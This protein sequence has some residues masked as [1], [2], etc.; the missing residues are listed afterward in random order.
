MSVQLILRH[1]QADIYTYYLQVSQL[2]SSL[3]YIS[4]HS[5]NTT[6][7]GPQRGGTLLNSQNRR[8]RL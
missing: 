6:V 5:A 3:I 4:S 8:A 1:F 7:L 2:K